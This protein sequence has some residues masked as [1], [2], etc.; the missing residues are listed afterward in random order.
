MGITSSRRSS[1]DEEEL[2]KQLRLCRPIP[3]PQYSP[4]LWVVSCRKVSSCKSFNSESLC[5]QP[6]TRLFCN[7]G[8]CCK[9][10][11][12]P[13]SEHGRLFIH[14]TP[15]V[16]QKMAEAAPA[17]VV[18]NRPSLSVKLPHVPRAWAL[19]ATT[20]AA[21]SE[22]ASSA[23]AVDIPEELAGR[24]VVVWV[25]GFRQRYFRVISVASHLA[26]QLGCQ[27]GDGE[28]D[29][30]GGTASRTVVLAFLWPSHCNKAAYGLA[31]ADAMRAA[32]R[33]TATLSALRAAGCCV[34][35][36]AHSMGCR[37]ALTALTA[38]DTST[39][40]PSQPSTA[41]SGAKVSVPTGEAGCA[42]GA[43]LCSHLFLLAA[44]VEANSLSVG[45][46]FAL[47]RLR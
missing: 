20:D 18:I 3:A 31:R 47:E 43:E 14:T 33:L 41:A 1:C 36:I 25:H 17:T 11:N 32:P 13:D 40:A 10:L 2:D 44:A 6:D 8:M 23:S 4:H 26:H 21:V 12:N 16:I 7:D 34:T 24:R 46:E 22:S 42:P 45:G 30:D 37:V 19:R 27:G 9:L 15:G 5:F 38:E 39:T 29:E 28:G 35:V